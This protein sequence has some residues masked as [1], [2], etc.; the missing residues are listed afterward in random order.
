MIYDTYIKMFKALVPKNITEFAKKGKGT[1]KDGIVVYALAWF[2]TLILG[3]IGFFLT[4][5]T[6]MADA[7]TL[8]ALLGVDLAGVFGIVL[9]VVVSIFGLFWGI[10]L[11]Y[12]SQFAGAFSATRFF[13]G[14]GKFENQFYL[15]MLFS[16]AIL[17][18]GSVFGLIEAVVPALGIITGAIM[19]VISIWSLYLLYY[20]LREIH[21]I[22]LVG[23]L[24]ST[25]VVVGVS[26][27]LAFFIALVLTLIGVAVLGAGALGGM[28]ASGGL[29]NLGA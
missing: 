28:A 17:I 14:K 20:T 25:I 27:I 29:G 16:G 13:K 11:N 24:I 15:V 6:N 7:K 26:V 10:A 12:I 3:I 23:A 5:G 4:L 2:I 21:K 1:V 9:L 19:L 22:D 18:I 8:G